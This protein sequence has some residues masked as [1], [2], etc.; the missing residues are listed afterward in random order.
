MNKLIITNYNNSTLT[1]LYDDKNM[2]EVSL[3]DNATSSFVGDVYVGRVENIVPSINAA[4]VEFS[5]GIKGYL[6]MSEADY[7]PYFINK[8]NTEKLC[9]GDLILV[10]VQKDQI[11]TKAAVLTTNINLSGN[12]CVVVSKAA[13]MVMVS[14]K[15]KNKERKNYYKNLIMPHAKPEYGIIAR[16]NCENAE[17]DDI[18]AEVKKNVAL[19]DEMY[20]KSLH[21]TAFTCLYKEKRGYI[22]AVK[23]VNFETIDQVLTDDKEIY[24]NIKEYFATDSL[25]KDK[26]AFY[27]DK[28]LPL[29]KLYSVD[30]RIKEALSERVWLKS[31]GYLVI[32]VTEAMVVIDVN[33]GKF[34][35]NNKN[36]DATFFKINK[37][38]AEEIAHH[39]RL[40]NYSGI[41]IIDFIDMES[42][43][44]NREL[45]EELKSLIAS[46]PVKTV[47]VDMTSLGLVE[48]T[49]K[50]V[51][52]PLY[53]QIYHK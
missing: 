19:M 1:A 8:K 23:N 49:R 26:I 6:S 9:L 38:A 7:K 45:I 22:N 5:K 48:L 37:Q 29:A 32:Q 47:Y 3:E 24:D 14:D 12:F 25:I 16:T 40:R 15:I 18:V 4:F 42:R 52:R 10:Q 20:G 43:E 21:S 46:D 34:S 41:I 2:V 51:K 11:K 31:G 33:T 27:E 36:T 53:E 35:G 44:Y 30:T 39:I 17:D 50:K 28:L 13:D